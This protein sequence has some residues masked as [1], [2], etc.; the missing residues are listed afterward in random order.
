MRKRRTTGLRLCGLA[1]LATTLLLCACAGANPGATANKAGQG[2][3]TDD[4]KIILTY[5]NARG[6]EAADRALLDRYM[7]LNPNVDV[8]YLST[9]ALGG[10]S[11]TDAIA[12]LTFRYRPRTP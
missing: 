3:R 12:N 9:V 4:G 10:A 8:E 5:F 7:E 11:D 1:L 6:A 2:A